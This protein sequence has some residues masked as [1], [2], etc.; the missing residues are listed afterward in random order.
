MARLA[1]LAALLLVLHLSS[2]GS[3]VVVGRKG[4]MVDDEPAKKENAAP[5]SVGRYAVIFDAGSTG[6]R[7][8]GFKF[9]KKM[10][11]LEIGDDIEFFIKVKPGLSSYA[12]RPQEAANSMLPLLEKATATVPRWLQ[13][14]TLLKL[15]V[16][17]IYKAKD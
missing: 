2:A 11:L 9:D 3:S 12:G 16:A 1:G 13:K 5:G 8:H 6:S 17:V 10:G 15:G 14:N 4:S 7:V